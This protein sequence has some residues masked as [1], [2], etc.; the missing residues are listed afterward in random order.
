MTVVKNF[1][2]FSGPSIRLHA[3]GDAVLHLRHRGH[4]ALRL[5]H[6]R[7][8]HFHREA[9]QLQA[10]LPVTDVALQVSFEKRGK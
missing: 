5:N 6:Q 10:H 2:P 7:P 8:G 3:D 4:A 9:Q 1:S